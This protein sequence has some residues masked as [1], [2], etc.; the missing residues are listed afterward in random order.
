MEKNSLNY[1]LSQKKVIKYE[2]FLIDNDLK[3]TISK[4]RFIILK[5]NDDFIEDVNQIIELL[6]NIIDVKKIIN[7]SNQSLILY[8]YDSEINFNQLIQT[9]NFD[10]GASLQLFFGGKL[11]SNVFDDNNIYFITIF[12]LMNSSTDYYY[13]NLYLINYLLKTDQNKLKSIKE[14]ILYK[15]L[16]D[17]SLMMVLDAMF[18][19]DLNVSKASQN[20][21]M[22]RNTVNNKLE[23]IK[24]NTGLNVQ[25][26][27]HACALYTLLH[28]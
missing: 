21:F 2:P 14:D 26:F 27:K 9:I 18:N 5:F 20:I 8:S 3:D 12:E 15:I 10:F 22:H 17:S 1:I 23:L 4:Y 7:T 13:D 28:N 11:S 25:I 24:E 6:H 19:N 16:N